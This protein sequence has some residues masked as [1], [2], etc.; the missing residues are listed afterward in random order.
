[1]GDSKKVHGYD[2]LVR[3]MVGG[4]DRRCGN[5]L[6]LEVGKKDFPKKTALKK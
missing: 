2:N 5:C 1:M 4:Q 6:V 3:V